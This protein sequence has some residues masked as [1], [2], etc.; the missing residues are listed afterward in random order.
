LFLIYNK[1]IASLLKKNKNIFFAS[2]LASEACF[3]SVAIASGPIAS[4]AIASGP[5]A[6]GPIASG[7][8]ASVAIASGAIA[9]GPIAS[10][11]IASGPIG[12]GAI[13]TLY[14]ASCFATSP[15]LAIV[16][17][18]KQLQLKLGTTS[19]CPCFARTCSCFSEASNSEATSVTKIIIKYYIA[20]FEI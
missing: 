15:L 12:S 18:A 6:S 4:V 14:L 17:A 19:N 5:I 10:G 2:S 1:R 20:K 3:A 7:P 8:I 13:G 16:V 11:A 9:S